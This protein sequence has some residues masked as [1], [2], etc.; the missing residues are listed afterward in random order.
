MRCEVSRW[1]NVLTPIATKELKSGEQQLPSSVEAAL[2]ACGWLNEHGK[3]AYD[4]AT[5]AAAHPD[6]AFAV[7]GLTITSFHLQQLQACIQV[8]GIHVAVLAS[9]R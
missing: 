7:P 5:V 4:G 6:D 8:R 1:Y 3:P 9:C 2:R